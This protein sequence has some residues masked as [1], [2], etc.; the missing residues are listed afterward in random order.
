MAAFT[1]LL[2]PFR[3]MTMPYVRRQ[4]EWQTM[5][6]MAEVQYNDNIHSLIQSHAREIQLIHRSWLLQQ[7]GFPNFG[8]RNQ[9]YRRY[10]SHIKRLMRNG[11]TTVMLE[12]PALAIYHCMQIDYANDYDALKAVLLKIYSFTYRDLKSKQV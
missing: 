2:I 8:R 12:G 4:V 1:Q 6:E 11:S 9:P 5:F 10:V 7:E 3:F